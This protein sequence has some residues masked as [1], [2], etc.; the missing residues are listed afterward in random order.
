MTALIGRDVRMARMLRRRLARCK[1][2]GRTAMRAKEWGDA[3]KAMRA[4]ERLT[5][6]EAS[7]RDAHHANG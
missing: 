1:R 3:A 7:K 2:R 5:R 6:S 4:A